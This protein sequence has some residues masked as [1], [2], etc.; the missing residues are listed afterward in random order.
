MRIAIALVLLVL[1]PV[2]AWAQAPIQLK[3]G[4]GVG[5]AH[6]VNDALYDLA[7]QLD[8]KT[9]GKLKLDVVISNGLAKGEAAHLEGAQLG[10]IDI[11][12]IGSAP[13]GGMFE[14]AFQ[15]LAPPFFWS[16]RQQGWKGRDGPLRQR[17]PR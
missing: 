8:Q 6:P 16:S 10:T 12:P 4:T 9:G 15:A 17:A 5:P 1:A 3:A 13:I 7:K 14:P 2:V 11:V